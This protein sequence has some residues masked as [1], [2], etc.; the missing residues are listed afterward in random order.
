MQC[1]KGKFQGTEHFVRDREIFEI[2]GSR[3]RES[4]LYKM[5]EP[6]FNQCPL[7]YKLNMS[8]NFLRYLG[9]TKREHRPNMGQH[10]IIL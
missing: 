2:E 8:E 7:C 4:P 5:H 10:G 3:D 1:S 9:S 6:M